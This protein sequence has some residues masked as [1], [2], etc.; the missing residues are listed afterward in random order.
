STHHSA[1]S[2]GGRAPVESRI[3]RRRQ[4]E[5]VMGEIDVRHAVV[6]GRGGGRELKCDVYTP[7]ERAQPA[8][9]LLL[10]H[11]GGWRQGE[12]AMLSGYGERF[13]AGGFVCVAPEYRLTPESPWPAQIHDVKAAIRW[14]RANAAELGIDAGQIA[15]LGSSAGAHLALQAAGS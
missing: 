5:A 13:G 1:H 10:L 9:A 14:V 11:G 12:P 15:A 8:P 7:S 2:A 3:V 4:G 6:F